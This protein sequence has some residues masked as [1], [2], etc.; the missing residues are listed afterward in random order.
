MTLFL[1]ATILNMPLPLWIFCLQLTLYYTCISFLSAA[2][3]MW[4]H[5]YNYSVVS[6]EHHFLHI[7]NHFCLLK[8]FSPLLWSLTLGDQSMICLSHLGLCTLQSLILCMLISWW[9]LVNWHYWS[10]G[11][12]RSISGEDWEILP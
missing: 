10:Y 8:S 11:K 4:V 5:T 9:F 6:S 7:I 12:R 2:Q 1:R 3:S